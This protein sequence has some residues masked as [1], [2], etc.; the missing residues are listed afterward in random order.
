MLIAF[1]RVL[2]HGGLA[3]HGY[4]WC[5]DSPVQWGGAAPPT[6]CSGVQETG[7][8]AAGLGN[9][10]PTRNSFLPSSDGTAPRPESWAEI[11]G[12]T[13]S[14]HSAEPFG[15]IPQSLPS[16]VHT[17]GV[18][19][20]DRSAVF[21]AP[22]RAWEL[23]AQRSHFWLGLPRPA[24]AIF[25]P[26]LDYRWSG[27]K[28]ARRDADSVLSQPSSSRRPLVADRWR[29]LEYPVPTG[30]AVG[31]RAGET[32]YDYRTEVGRAHHIHEPLIPSPRQVVRC[33]LRGAD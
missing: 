2:R 22:A 19:P 31:A 4:Q 27:A 28:I 21:P 16:L 11:L 8:F 29:V 30:P 26:A 23:R 17:H 15:L 7:A 3:P 12:R 33:H 13:R 18:E 20:R 9:W 14:S 24:A 32:N 25:R 5:Q 6:R 1:A 10:E